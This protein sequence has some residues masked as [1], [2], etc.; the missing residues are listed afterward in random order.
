MGTVAGADDP[1][2]SVP[3]GRI[4]L[5]GDVGGHAD[6]LAAAVRDLG[7][8]PDTGELPADLVVVQ[9][10]DL[11]DRGP[12][13][14]GSVRL[15][16]RFLRHGGGRWVQLWGNHEGQ[17]FCDLG[18]GHVD[19]LPDAELGTLLRWWSTRVVRLAV[20]L[21]TRELGGVL[22]THAGLSPAVWAELAAPASAVDVAA[23][24]NAWVGREPTRAFTPPGSDV[25]LTSGPGVTWGEPDEWYRAWLDAPSPPPFAQVHGHASAWSWRHGRWRKRTPDVVRDAVTRV[26]AARCH[27]WMDLRGCPV[28][29]IDPGHRGTPR[30][31]WAPPPLTG[32]LAGPATEPPPG[33]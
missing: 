9:V 20:A 4:A 24:L 7:G 27:L 14:A 17:R 16:D 13:S 32:G 30:M 31:W 18:L 12:D 19:P 11:V 33:R 26:D 28:V 23:G 10:G 6:E 8:D 21:R 3:S 29:G 1:L 22:V 5:I 15:V 2:E 25:L